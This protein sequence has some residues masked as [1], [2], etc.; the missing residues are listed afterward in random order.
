MSKEDTLI[1]FTDGSSRGNP[2]PGGYG[3]IVIRG[4]QVTELGGYSEETTN[5]RM[6]LTAVIKALQSISD[7]V[8]NKATIY[9]DSS[10]VLKGSTGWMYGWKKNGWKTAN[11]QEVLNQDLW[12][13]MIQVIELIGADALE[14]NLIKGHDGIVGNERADLIAT[15]FSEKKP[16]ELFNGSLETYDALLGESILKV[17]EISHDHPKRSHKKPFSYVSMVD[18]RVEIHASWADTENRVK[19]VS[20]AKFKKAISKIDEEKIIEEWQRTLF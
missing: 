7:D 11:K 13:D 5:N 8:K 12:Q 10:Y 19:G 4:S 18:G 1:I 15:S 3:S 2:G 14:W 9:T 6:E 16:L 20:G 17:P